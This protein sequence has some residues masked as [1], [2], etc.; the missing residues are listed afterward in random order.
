MMKS[1]TRFLGVVALSVTLIAT[2]SCKKEDPEPTP[3]ETPV[4][5]PPSNTFTDTRDGHEYGFIEIGTQTWMTENLVYVSSGSYSYNGV[6]SNDAT[7]GRLYEW[8]SVATAV[9]AGW[10][11]PTDDEWKTLETALGMPAGDLNIN[12]YGTSRG[13]DQG[14]QLKVG[15]SSGLDFPLAGYYDGSIYQALDDRTYLWVNTDAGGGNIFRRRLVTGDASC[16]RF[17]NAA[18]S[19]AIS[20]RLVRD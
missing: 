18:G 4:P 8:A 6:S 5:V 10:H 1:K 3:V 19:F 2:I 17:T 12:D 7:Y 15:G 14:T 13:T 11:L 16:Y 20:I 9:P